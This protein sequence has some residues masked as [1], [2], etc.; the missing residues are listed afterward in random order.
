M[1]NALKKS[2]LFVFVLI[3]FVPPPRAR[4]GTLE[5]SSQKFSFCP[6]PIAWRMKGTALGKG[7]L[8]ACEGCRGGG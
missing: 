5:K 8:V 1:R 6:V 7:G 3:V 2:L 4:S